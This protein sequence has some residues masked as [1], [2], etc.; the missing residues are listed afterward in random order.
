[1]IHP[2]PEMLHKVAYRLPV[3][4]DGTRSVSHWLRRTG[5]GCGVSKGHAWLIPFLRVYVRPGLRASLAA[6]RKRAWPVGVTKSDHVY[7]KWERASP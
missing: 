5:S 2:A 4:N 1:M 6:P 3:R 7:L